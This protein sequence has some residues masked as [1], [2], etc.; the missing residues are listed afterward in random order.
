VRLCLPLAP[1]AGAARDAVRGA[2]NA[3]EGRSA[4]LSRCQ[5]QP[6]G[7][8]PRWTLRQQL[9]VVQLPWIPSCR[10]LQQLEG[11]A[12]G[13]TRASRDWPQAVASREVQDDAEPWRA[14][15]M[16]E[17]KPKTTSQVLESVGRM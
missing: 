1:P 14:R 17:A 12:P 5:R 4:L 11:S 3:A 16:V 6:S 7:E 9:T 8:P 10:P 15:A 13:S 2:R